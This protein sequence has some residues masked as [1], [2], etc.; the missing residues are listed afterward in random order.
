MFFGLLIGYVAAFS[1]WLALARKWMSAS[2]LLAIMG[3]EHIQSPFYARVNHRWA[4][5]LLRLYRLGD[6]NAA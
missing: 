3:N 1:I 4:A 6:E 2:E 5:W